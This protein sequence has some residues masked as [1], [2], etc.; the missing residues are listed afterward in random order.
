MGGAGLF[1]NFVSVFYFSSLHDLLTEVS[2]LLKA[3]YV[4]DFSVLG[5]DASKD[6]W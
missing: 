1:F 2:L 5:C 4:W 6:C 3:N